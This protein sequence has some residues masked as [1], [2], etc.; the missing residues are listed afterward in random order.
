MIYRGRLLLDHDSLTKPDVK[1][2]S[3]VARSGYR[4]LRKP[5]EIYIVGKTVIR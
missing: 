2:T 5:V 3:N 4:Y 1:I